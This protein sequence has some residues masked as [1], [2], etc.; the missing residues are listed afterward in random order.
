MS[1]NLTWALTQGHNVNVVKRDGLVFSQ[2]RG[3]VMNVNS[4]RFTPILNKKAVDVSI[5]PNGKTIS[6]STTRRGACCKP[7]KKWASTNIHNDQKT[8]AH[9][10]NHL[11]TYGADKNTIKLSQKRAYI[12]LRAIA[13]KNGKKQA[14]AKKD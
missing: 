8:Y 4:A 9:L 10:R 6:V 14:P 1:R 13:R 11:K 3:N 2:E 7:A 12:L 5:A